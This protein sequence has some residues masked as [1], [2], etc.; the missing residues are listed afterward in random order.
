MDPILPVFVGLF[1]VLLGGGLTYS[2]A[3]ISSSFHSERLRE[4]R[5][6]EKGLLVLRAKAV[7]VD[8]VAKVEIAK[9]SRQP[10]PF[11]W[12]NDLPRILALLKGK[13]D[14][15]SIL[16]D[17]EVAALIGSLEDKK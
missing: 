11:S 16:E 2:G 17:P 5:L 6:A 1:L 15:K 13:G 14:I 10:T 12:R 7:E 8:S 3:R 9:L 4:L